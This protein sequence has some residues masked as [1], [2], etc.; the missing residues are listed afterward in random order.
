MEMKIDQEEQI[1]E[2]YLEMFKML[3]AYA[4]SSLENESLAE[5]AVQEA[6]QIACAKAEE[7]C[8]SP[9][10]KGWITNT[11]KNVIRNTKRKQD[12]TSHLFANYV[13]ANCRE[14]SVTEDRISLEILY[15]SVADTEDFR[16]IKEMA[17][18][19]RSQLEIAM[20][21]GITLTACKKRVQRAKEA[22]RKKLF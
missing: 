16:L 8:K 21:R 15:G 10:P 6:F 14:I 20:S 5:E 2:L 12:T 4:R 7:L 11:L 9:N 18:D 13:A 19:G 3:V 17:V 1:H 22:L